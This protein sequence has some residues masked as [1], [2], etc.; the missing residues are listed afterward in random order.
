MSE[1]K[2]YWNGNAKYSKQYEKLWD[3]LVPG[4]GE[5]ETVKGE[6]VRIVGRITHEY[7]NNG[8]FNAIE[9]Q[10]YE[11]G[12]GSSSVTPYYKEMFDFIEDHTEIE[13]DEFI[14][15]W[16]CHDLYGNHKALFSKEM[17]EAYTDFLDSVMEAAIDMDPNKK[18]PNYK[19]E[20]V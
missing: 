19:P 12:F 2:S 17:E 6:L 14:H 4:S 13:P 7:Y 8:N 11:D 3:E 16:Y 10:E 20:E 5:A 15:E 9:T 1:V 18:N